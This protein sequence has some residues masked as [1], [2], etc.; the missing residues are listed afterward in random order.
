MRPNEAGNDLLTL[1]V[2]T[3]NKEEKKGIHVA[4]EA[5]TGLNEQIP[6]GVLLYDKESGECLCRRVFPQENVV[7][8]VRYDFLEDI[9]AAN[10]S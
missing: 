10:I 8:N 2:K 1:G 9:E 7:G 3:I 5:K 6:C 4:F